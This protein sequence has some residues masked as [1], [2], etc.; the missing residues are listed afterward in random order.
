LKRKK[1]KKKK[2]PSSKI[3]CWRSDAATSL[4]AG[5]L[6]VQL[7]HLALFSLLLSLLQ[8]SYLEKTKHTHWRL[9][10]AVGQKISNGS[11]SVESALKSIRSDLDFYNNSTAVEWKNNWKVIIYYYISIQKLNVQVR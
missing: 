9:E 8:M 10:E 3:K 2:N 6:K 4:T 5:Y 11:P 7:F 1:K